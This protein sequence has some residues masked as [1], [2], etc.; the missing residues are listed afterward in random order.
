MHVYKH[1]S[2]K[3]GKSID[4]RGPQCV[5]VGATRIVGE[6][7]LSPI[8]KIKYT[9]L[10]SESF[11][12]QSETTGQAINLITSSMSLIFYSINIL[13][14][15]HF[16]PVTRFNPR[17]PAY[18]WYRENP[19]W[20]SFTPNTTCERATVFFFFSKT[21]VLK[22]LKYSRRWLQSELVVTYNKLCLFM[23]FVYKLHYNIIITSI[24]N[25]SFNH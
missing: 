21:F 22:Q 11:I 14:Y 25:N 20:F 8:N 17:S 24:K 1:I 13:R 4:V 12:T 18:F 2:G 5:R 9:I 10:F 16:T 15:P 6:Q 3:L 23:I 7:S 19:S